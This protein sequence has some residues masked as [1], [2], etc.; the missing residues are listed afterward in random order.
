LRPERFS[1]PP[2]PHGGVAFIPISVCLEAQLW[3]LV[4]ITGTR[5]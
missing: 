4:G 1:E 2:C 5:T 3:E